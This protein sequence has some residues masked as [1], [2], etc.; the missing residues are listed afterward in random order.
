MPRP[1]G[2]PTRRAI[3]RL[4]KVSKDQ[5]ERI[6]R[7]K[8][9]LDAEQ[10]G[11]A[12]ALIDQ[13]QRE[14]AAWKEEL[15]SF[16]AF[17][18]TARDPAAWLSVA[19]DLQAAAEYIDAHAVAHS[20][21]PAEEHHGLY[22]GALMLTAFSIENSLKAMLVARG[23]VSGTLGELE[24]P[25]RDGHDLLGLAKLLKWSPAEADAKLLSV[26]SHLSRWATRY[27]VPLSATTSKSFERALDD[28]DDDASFAALGRRIL[29]GAGAFLERRSN[30]LALMLGAA[31]LT[32]AAALNAAS[33]SAPRSTGEASSTDSG[34]S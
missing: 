16:A 9:L 14:S 21:E 15:D 31:V 26:L 10:L 33:G 23:E 11:K 2:K 29:S 13:T 8:V 1:I 19:R 17:D 32:P 6:A 27:P 28:V 4:K 12:E 5:D 34:S 20:G 25:W 7:I 30:A 18:E 22:R 24:S 3:E